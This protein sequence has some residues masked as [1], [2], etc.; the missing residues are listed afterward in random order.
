[1]IQ[2]TESTS[3]SRDC[4]HQLYGSSH[5]C[6]PKAAVYSF[7]LP[8]AS[9]SREK[10]N[11]NLLKNDNYNWRR[12]T[13]RRVVLCNC[14][15]LERRINARKAAWM[16][17]LGMKWFCLVGVD[18]P[19]FPAFELS[20]SFVCY[21]LFVVRR[22][23]NLRICDMACK[24]PLLW[25]PSGF[26]MFLKIAFSKSTTIAFLKPAISRVLR[27]FSNLYYIPY[28]SAR[29]RFVFKQMNCE[30]ARMSR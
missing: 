12:W 9:K 25:I 6:W 11:E 27:D 17:L 10:T 5:D 29:A 16:C 4:T 26:S 2:C 18:L 22:L 19:L 28:V 20:Y 23:H 21:F 3:P 7:S 14:L 8:T 30:F 1:M 24:L 13:F 15:Q